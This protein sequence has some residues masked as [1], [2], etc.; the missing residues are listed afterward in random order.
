MN[1]DGSGGVAT[2][3]RFGADVPY[4]PGVGILVAGLLLA[5][6][7]IAAITAGAR[8]PPT[9]RPA[10]PASWRERKRMAAAYEQTFAPLKPLRTSSITVAAPATLGG[11]PGPP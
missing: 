8:R 3:S 2:R 11:G 10:G 4:L 7:G 1:A 6:G 9:A 5:A